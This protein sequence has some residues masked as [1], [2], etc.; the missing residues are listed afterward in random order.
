MS[1]PDVYT[2]GDAP[3]FGETS[4]ADVVERL[5]EKGVVI[6]A[7]LTLSLAGVDLVYLGLRAMLCSADQPEA[8]AIMG[9]SA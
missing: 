4:L 6:T 8:R 3:S 2:V 7:D 9:H 1:Q 5:L